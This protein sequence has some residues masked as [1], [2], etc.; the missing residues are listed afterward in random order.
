MFGTRTDVVKRKIV[1]LVGRERINKWS[2]PY[3]DYVATRQTRKFLHQ[4]TG[5]SL[6][7]NLGSGGRPLPGWVNVDIVRAPRVDVIWDLRRPLPFREGSAEAILA[8]HVVE[9]L[10]LDEAEALIRD[11]YR[12]LE[13]SGVLRLS[14]PDAEKYLRSYVEDDGFLHSPEF[15]HP[16]ELPL[17]RVNEMFR[18]DGLHRWVYDRV[19]LVRLFRRGGFS[20]IEPKSCGFSGNPALRG[21]D[22]ADRAFESL[23]VEGRKHS[24]DVKAVL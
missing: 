2:R 24:R 22:A 15:S 17:D 6:R 18:E 4:L 19:S 12:I 13:P 3:Y 7:I 9:H 14:T 11:C 8:E 16:V 1:S 5:H 10:E 21:I 20:N 23:Y